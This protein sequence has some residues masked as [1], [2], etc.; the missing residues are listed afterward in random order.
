MELAGSVY[1][2]AIAALG[3]TFATMSA[4][5]VVL[6]HTTGAAISK[7]QLYLTRLYVEQGFLAAGY[8]IL[9]MLIA[10]FE[11]PNSSV[12]RLSSGIVCAAVMLRMLAV[13]R[14][15]RTAAETPYSR[16]ARIN[17][18][19]IGLT[20]LLLL[21]NALGIPYQPGPGMYALAVTYLLGQACFTFSAR[22]GEFL[23]S[24]SA[25]AAPH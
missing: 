7:Y 12:W 24:V 3:M 17:I 19:M 21:I 1:L 2:Y 22:L 11:A 20:A 13:T 4:I 25:G 10:Q 9:P 15:H 14:R 16:P 18:G 23:A 5:V 8:S 6:R